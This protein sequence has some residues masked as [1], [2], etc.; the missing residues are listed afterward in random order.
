MT[1][2]GNSR[3]EAFLSKFPQV[4]LED[5]SCNITKRCKFNFSYF[6]SRQKAG[7]DL[8]TWD[9]KNL[10]S[11]VSKLIEY[12]REPLSYWSRMPIGSHQRNVLEIYGAFPKRSKFEHP[13]HVPSDVDWVR[14]RLDQKNDW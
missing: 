4:A 10:Q 9:E 5:E 2:R 3:K 12:T 6:D 7:A 8:V 13:S 1:R 11:F 14:F